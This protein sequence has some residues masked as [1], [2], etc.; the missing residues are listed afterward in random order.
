LNL[1]VYEAIYEG[2]MIFHC[3]VY[4]DEFYIYLYIES[5]YVC[6]V[7]WQILHPMVRHLSGISECIYMNKWINIIHRKCEEIHCGCHTR[8]NMDK[9]QQKCSFNIYFS[10]VPSRAGISWHVLQLQEHSWP[11]Q[12]DWLSDLET[13]IQCY[14]TRYFNNNRR[15][16]PKWNTLHRASTGCFGLVKFW[17]FLATQNALF[18]PSLTTHSF[19]IISLP[20]HNQCDQIH[21]INTISFQT[22]HLHRK[23][24]KFH[25]YVSPFLSPRRPLERAEV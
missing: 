22:K 12:L 1:L 8:D 16:I 21:A 2:L 14:K 7:C 17:M 9:E 18:V 6:Y 4:N 19:P 13:D 23:A 11:T 10:Y 24:N 15:F 25:R 3:Y 20:R 5:L